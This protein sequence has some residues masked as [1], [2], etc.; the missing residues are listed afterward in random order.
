VDFD[1]MRKLGDSLEQLAHMQAQVERLRRARAQI[2]TFVTGNYRD[3]ARM[4]VRTRADALRS[5]VTR[6]DERSSA[7]RGAEDALVAAETEITRIHDEQARVETDIARVDAEHEA[8][9]HS[10]RW[11]QVVDYDRATADAAKAD[12]RAELARDDLERATGE[13][14]TR[15][16][17]LAG[18]RDALD[19]GRR[20]L[21]ATERDL[22]GL[23]E[24]AGL[25]ARHETLREELFG[26]QVDPG[27]AI[28]ILRGEADTRRQRVSDADRRL[29]AIDRTAGRVETVNERITRLAGELDTARGQRSALAVI[30]EEQEDALTTAI[31]DW[32][33][34]L[35]EIQMTPELLERTV[36][37]ALTP[38]SAQPD[39]P[40]RDAAQ[41]RREVLAGDRA[42]LDAERE[43]IADQAEARGRERDELAAR[44]DPQPDRRGNLRA[45]RDH[46]LTPL[47][48]LVDFRDGLGDDERAQAEAALEEAGLL[49][50]LVGATERENDSRLIAAPVEGRS[51]ADV[52]VP[53]TAGS[54]VSEDAIIAIL[55]SVAYET[56]REVN[57][58]AG[59]FRLGPLHGT[60]SKPAAQ[61]I[62]AAAREQHRAALLARLEEQ[63]AE[64]RDQDTRL[65]SRADEIDGALAQVSTELG[66]F[67]RLDAL[68][69]ARANLARAEHAEQQADRTLRAERDS[70]STLMGEL[71]AARE[72]LDAFCSEHALPSDRPGLRAVSDVTRDYRAALG[73]ARRALSELAH[74]RAAVQQAERWLR[75]AD[76][77]VQ[78]ARHESTQADR[79][80]ARQ[81]GRLNAI[82][83]ALG[84]GME[85]IK[86]Q[87]AA[88]STQHGELATAQKRLIGEFTQA[89]VTRQARVGELERA[90]TEF[91]TA[92]SHRQRTLMSFRNLQSADMF[93]LALA[94]AAPEDHEHAADWTLTRAVEV[95]RAL[96][97]DRLRV[98]GEGDATLESKANLLQRDCSELDRVLAEYDMQVVIGQ[99]DSM[100][101]VRINTGGVPQTVNA[102]VDSLGHELEVRELALSAEQQRIFGD[103]LIEEISEHLRQRITGVRENVA[104]INEKL[105]RCQTGSGKTVSLA[106]DAGE[107][108]GMD[109][110]PIVRLI[111][112]RSIAA[113]RADQRATLVEFFRRRIEQAREQHIADADGEHTTAAFLMRAFDYRAW[114]EFDLFQHDLLTGRKERLTSSRHATGS[115]GEQAVLMHMPLFAAAAALYD[116]ARSGIAPRLIALDEALSGIDEETR[117]H[118]LR[119][120]V[121][122]DL[123]VFLT[124]Y[125]IKPFYPTVPRISAYLLH[126]VNGE[127][128]VFAEWFEWD[129][130][131]LVQR[132]LEDPNL[133]ML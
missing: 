103:T 91:R 38:I 26:G 66:R 123:D 110:D 29:D 59:R 63:I 121:E 120:T 99:T 81:Q 80:A 60:Y 105:G 9:T 68:H 114:F 128:G 25:T 133:Q 97:E 62:G 58:S 41:A 96:P 84:S 109:M 107:L 36:D 46:T 47:W 108:D 57:V 12:R 53:V 8:L 3:Y 21:D 90:E 113:L 65:L 39:R 4:S 94:D 35:L 93:R 124:A 74:R 83:L 131:M 78:R 28:N 70:L 92:D 95:V 32:A 24:L 37:C 98:R 116:S 67:P 19:E 122:L 77:R 20:D 7:R 6:Y 31:E 52:L 72:Q 11:A 18:A 69:N 64:L 27:A 55:H 54:G 34:E 104:A 75:E 76:A 17:E 33:S 119:V 85:E 51:L 42:R 15:G 130:V 22:H 100:T 79:E 82:A 30:A 126:R 115:G 117:P 101:I 44:R 14:T 132:D 112:G 40:W 111:A 129:G 89:S 43:R 86:A 118:V 56:D 48:R 87:V 50:A 16:E 125:E 127:W 23:A 45:D 88:L 73:G 13:H 61:F 5:A 10:E 49:D 1:L 2:Q 71:T 102:L 106:W